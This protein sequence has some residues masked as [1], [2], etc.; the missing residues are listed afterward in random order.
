MIKLF[1]SDAKFYGIAHGDGRDFSL[2]PNASFR[3]AIAWNTDTGDVSVTVQPSCVDAI[4]CSPPLAINLS[5]DD[6]A[7]HN[8]VHLSG[9]NGTLNVKLNVQDAVTSYVPHIDQNISV[10]FG[11]GHSTVSIKGDPYPDFEVNQ[12]K[13]DGTADF[14]ARSPHENPGGPEVNL[15]PTAPRREFTWVD[16]EIQGGPVQGLHDLKSLWCQEEP[17]SPVCFAD[18]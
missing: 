10:S 18:H 9:G 14:L 7:H 12:Y 11:D 16:G 3:V 5:D 8:N 13:N 17:T 4:G 1:I 6:L 2:D 15:L